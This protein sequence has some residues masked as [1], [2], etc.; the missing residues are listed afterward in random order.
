MALV[1]ELQIPLVLC[2]SWQLAA[3]R[4]TAKGILEESERDA[5]LAG[6]WNW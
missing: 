2:H 4:N 6:L 3:E 5:C 1:S